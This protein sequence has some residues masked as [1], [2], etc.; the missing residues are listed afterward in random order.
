MLQILAPTA[1]PG[2]EKLFST[3][4][5]VRAICSLCCSPWHLEWFLSLWLQKQALEGRGQTGRLRIKDLETNPRSC[6][7]WWQLPSCL[8]PW[9]WIPC[10]V[11]LPFP[12]A[13][14]F[15]QPRG[16]PPQLSPPCC[17]HAHGATGR[18]WV[19]WQIGRAWLQR[20]KSLPPA[21]PGCGRNHK[22]ALG[23]RL[24]SF[25]HPTVRCPQLFQPACSTRPCQ[26]PTWAQTHEGSHKPSSQV[27]LVRM[28]QCHLHA[29]CASTPY[30]F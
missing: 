10:C 1:T 15:E 12:L 14:Q 30:W 27:H 25:L 6:F 28:L 7:S 21:P 20:R 8:T 13:A 24:S 2:R 9:Q 5:C 19:A 11:S 16:L 4:S 18:T 17:R 23:C 26:Q 3:F 29:G 22:I